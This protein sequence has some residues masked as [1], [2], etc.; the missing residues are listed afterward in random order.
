MNYQSHFIDFFDTSQIYLDILSSC[1]SALHYIASISDEQELR[2][3]ATSLDFANTKLKKL[4]TDYSD[5]LRKKNK[6]EK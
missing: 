1:S 6:N 3:I 5:L 2:S 4:F